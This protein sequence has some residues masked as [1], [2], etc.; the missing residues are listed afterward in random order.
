MKGSPC[1]FSSAVAIRNVFLNNATP[2]AGPAH[3]QQ[4]L[5]P[6]LAASRRSFSGWNTSQNTFGSFRTPPSPERREQRVSDGRTL[7]HNIKSQMVVIRTKDG[8]LSEPQDKLEVLR[9]LDL[10]KSAL[11]ML[12]E[13]KPGRPF[14][15]CRIILHEEEQKKAYREMKNEKSKLQKQVKV[16][17][18]EIEIN[19]AMAP[20]DLATKIR[21]LKGF[22]EKGYRV[23]VTLMHPKKKSKRKA[24]EDEAKQVF[25][26][27]IK[28]LEEVPGTSEYK[29]RQGDV[30]RTKLLFLQGKVSKSNPAAEE[31][32]VE[33]TADESSASE[34]DAESLDKLETAEG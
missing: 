4:L 13:P 27:V 9:N 29:A 24:R 17:Q 8:T 22:L 19:W 23:D 6:S 21:R 11:E 7:N 34:E 3:F 32:A 26:E 14:P 16:A 2:V 15:I 20:H 33:E 30:G 18:K 5:L 31:E 25:Q 1:I 28:V 12:A 10:D